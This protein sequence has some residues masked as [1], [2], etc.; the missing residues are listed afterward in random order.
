MASSNDELGDVVRALVAKMQVYDLLLTS[1]SNAISVLI[2]LM[3][4]TL[5]QCDGCQEAP[6]TRRAC[7]LER[8]YCDKCSVRVIAG[9]LD[10]E[11]RINLITEGSLKPVEDWNDLAHAKDVR[12]ITTFLET[13]E[14]IKNK[15]VETKH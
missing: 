2:S 14:Q 11:D 8:E 13:V 7:H 3:R 1:T 15:N 6:A 9:T 10:D 12:F 5:K 4:A